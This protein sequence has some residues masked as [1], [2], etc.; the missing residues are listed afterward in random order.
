MTLVQHTSGDNGWRTP[1]HILARV[2]RSFGKDIDLD[3]ATSFEANVG[4]GAR[5]VYTEAMN[6]LAQTWGSETLQP[7]TYC[8][9]PGGKYPKG[10][11]LGG[12]SKTALF[13]DK[14]MAELALGH[15]DQAIF[16]CFSIS[17]LQVLQGH[18]SAPV[19]SFPMC[20]PAKRLAFID[21]TDAERDGP[22]HANAIV[23][24]P[25]RT[26]RTAEFA[27]HFWDIG[28]IMAPYGR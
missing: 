27:Q 14:L 10:H 4:V 22:S 15:I 16:M 11:E 3:P 2:R 9:P 17:S 28:G 13:W 8:N 21:P 18:G 24:V 23:Y 7:T 5:W 12:Q 19:T 6:G 25:G 20:I 1:G 26:D